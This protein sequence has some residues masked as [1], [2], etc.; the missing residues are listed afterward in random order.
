MMGSSELITKLFLQLFVILLTCRC[1]TVIGKRFLGQTQV[2]CEMAVGIVLGPSFLG[3]IAPTFQTYL[4]PNTQLVLENGASILH[5][6]MSILH[7]LSQLGLVIYLFLIGLDFDMTPVK[8]RFTST[9]LISATGILSPLLLGILITPLIYQIPNLFSSHVSLPN[10]ALF[11]GSAI[12]ITAFPMLARIIYEHKLMKTSF[13]ALAL[14]AGALDDAIVWLLLAGILAFFNQKPM[15]FIVTLVGAVA[16]ILFFIYLGQKKLSQLFSNEKRQQHQL[17][18]VL[19]ILICCAWLTD[20]IGIYAIFGSFL[21]GLNMPKD[22]AFIT[23]IRNALEPITINLL[24]PLFFVYSGLNT[25]LSLINSFLLIL[26]TLFIILV[27]C[28]GKG[29]AC[30]LAAKYAGETW[31]NASLIGILMNARGLMELIILNI[32]LEHH[33]I[34]PTLFSMLVMMAIITTF[35][36]SP[37]FHYLCHGALY[38]K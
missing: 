36:A 1:V 38:E 21:A 8:K 16:Y 2:V 33:L 11:L 28:L 24:L 32:G 3:L 37:L 31:K 4:F 19:L 13:G 29:L 14:S 25:Q 5:P 23:K 6:S 27:A 20:A 17:F 35:I 30:T 9:L 7:A 26:V 10:A 34:T 15:M 18:Y 12:S 22:K